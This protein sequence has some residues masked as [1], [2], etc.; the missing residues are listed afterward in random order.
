MASRGRKTKTKA[1]AEAEAETTTTMTT[2]T[3]W[4]MLALAISRRQGGFNNQQ[5]QEVAMEGS[6]VGADGSTMMQ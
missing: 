2:K 6:G 4:T 3:A 5:V 1:E